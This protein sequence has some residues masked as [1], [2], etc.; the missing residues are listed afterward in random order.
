VFVTIA[1]FVFEGGRGNGH[2]KWWG[3]EVTDEYARA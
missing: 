1:F 3:I 2:S